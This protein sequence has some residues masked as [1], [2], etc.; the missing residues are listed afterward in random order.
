MNSKRKSR[1]Q[2]SENW[3]LEVFGILLLA[4]FLFSLTGGISA[5]DLATITIT[6]RQEVRHSGGSR[7]PFPYRLSANEFPCVFG[8]KSAGAN[9]AGRNN[10]ERIAASDRLVVRIARNR[11][12][13]LQSEGV[14]IPVYSLERNGVLLFG[15]D[16]F[17]AAQARIDRAWGGFLLVMGTLL[18]YSGLGGRFWPKGLVV[19]AVA[20]AVAVLLAFLGA[21]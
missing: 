8:V 3:R 9:A 5:N 21:W 13:D 16:A 17:L 18:L 19:G 20:A 6:A 7:N 14:T 1:R 10:L 2:F 4:G 11:L 15:L 12:P